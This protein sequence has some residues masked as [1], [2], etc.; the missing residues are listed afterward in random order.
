M[1]KIIIL[2]LLCLC[3]VSCGLKGDLYLPDK[4]ENK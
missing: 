3:S 1:K 4:H 2:L